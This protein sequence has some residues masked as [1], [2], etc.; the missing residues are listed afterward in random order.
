MTTARRLAESSI[1]GLMLLFTGLIFTFIIFMRWSGA[2]PTGDG[3]GLMHVFDPKLQS[4]LLGPLWFILCSVRSIR[5][6]HGLVLI[7]SASRSRWLIAQTLDGLVEAVQVALPVLLVG[8]MLSLGGGHSSGGEP[9]YLVALD[10]SL[11]LMIFVLFLVSARVTLAGAALIGRLPAVAAFGTM[12]VVLGM[13]T[14]SGMPLP[15]VVSAISWQTWLSPEQASVLTSGGYAGLAAFPVWML[16]LHLA[17]AISE[18]GRQAIRPLLR[19]CRVLLIAAAATLLQTFLILPGGGHPT[20]SIWEAL[21]FIYYGPLIDRIGAPLL[22]VFLALI[23]FFGPVMLM[24]SRFDEE[25]G[26]WLELIMIRSGTPARW[27]RHFLGR[28]LGFCVI[29]LLLA[30]VF[31]VYAWALL[32]DNMRSQ[33]D[34]YVDPSLMGAR[35]LIVGVPQ[36]VFYGLSAF[37]AAWTARRAGAGLVVVVS[38]MVGGVANPLFGGWLPAYLNGLGRV[39]FGWPGVFK[40]LTILL[41]SC[42]VCLTILCVT[43]HSSY[44]KLLSGASSGRRKWQPLK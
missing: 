43:L 29:I 27:V 28:W 10:F 30:P 6:A 31:T 32:P 18:G 14:A 35:Y 8:V 34:P 38:L 7:R 13:A 26:A 44:V 2:L 25:S 19:S 11:R 21:G 33:D 12:M 16:M 5:A 17:A 9:A 42:C 24:L 37:L 36:V 41:I 3:P 1:S 40:D 15:S 23:M 20:V 39:E 4:F 22:P